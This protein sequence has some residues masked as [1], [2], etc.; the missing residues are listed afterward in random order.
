MDAHIEFT[1]KRW[2]KIENYNNIGK[3]LKGTYTILSREQGKNS[4]QE[5]RMKF[6]T[7]CH[8]RRLS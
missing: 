8:P 3:T 5:Q 7:K 2:Q 6:L 1:V 4:N